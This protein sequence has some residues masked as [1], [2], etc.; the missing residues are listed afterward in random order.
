MKPVVIAISGKLTKDG[1]KDVDLL[2][3]S[4]FVASPSPCNVIRD[5]G[6]PTTIGGWIGSPEEI[7]QIEVAKHPGYIL[8]ERGHIIAEPPVDDGKLPRFA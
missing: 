3:H 7:F 6:T 8:K 2:V 4:C 5:G 1:A